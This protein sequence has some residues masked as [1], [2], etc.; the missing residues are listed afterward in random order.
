MLKKIIITNNPL[1]REK[2]QASAE[3]LDA[4]VEGVLKRVRNHIHSGA[5]LVSHPLSGSMLPGINPYK[6]I[7]VALTEQSHPVTTDASSIFHIENAISLLREAPNGSTG[8]DE[9]TLEDFRV[10]DLDLLDFT[11]NSSGL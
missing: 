4:G 10:M 1:A 2:Y 8:Y 5:V 11:V 9:K 3:Y 6:S 7:V